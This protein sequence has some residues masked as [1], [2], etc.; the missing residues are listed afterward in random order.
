MSADTK[1]R[2]DIYFGLSAGVI[3]PVTLKASASESKYFD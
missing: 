3:I 1:A 2:K